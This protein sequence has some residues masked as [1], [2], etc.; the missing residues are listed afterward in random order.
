MALIWQQQNTAIA[1]TN[2]LVRCIDKGLLDADIVAATIDTAISQ[3]KTRRDATKSN[4]RA[5]FDALIQSIREGA[6]EGL[7][8]DTIWNALLTVGAS[9]FV[10]GVATDLLS[11][12]SAN[13][14]ASIADPSRLG[15]GG[16]F[17]HFPAFSQQA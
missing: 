2:N 8:T 11:V 6:N 5:D 3:I 15:G 9:P 14:P 16:T 4:Q 13:L 12:S 10:A 1:L 17:T 7:F